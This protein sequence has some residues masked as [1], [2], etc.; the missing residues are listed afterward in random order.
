M[1]RR[2]IYNRPIRR[3]LPPDD[4]DFVEV[5]A[6]EVP[7]AGEVA[8]AVVSST[9]RAVQGAAAAALV[10]AAYNYAE[11][12]AVSYALETV[13]VTTIVSGAYTV[14]ATV[15]PPVV[16]TAIAVGPTVATTVGTLATAASTTPGMV[17]AGAVGAKY[18]YDKA[19]APAVEG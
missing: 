8:S 13:G 6:T 2:P 3:D 16:N 15:I 5:K 17:V 9:A 4:D 19:T 11:S 12:A 1:P 7:S 14:A 18:I 10:T